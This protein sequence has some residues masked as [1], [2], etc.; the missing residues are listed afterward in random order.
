MCDKPA[1][2]INVYNIL[3]SPLCIEIEDGQKV[4][5]I[6]KRSIEEK[7]KIILSFQNIEVVT[8]AFFNKAIGQLYC[9]YNEEEI[10]TY[11]KVKDMFR[12]DKTLL[13]RTVDTSR[14]RFKTPDEPHEL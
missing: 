9:K 13:R 2:K 4:F 14:L 6:I 11:L 3:N 12:Q 5:E 7:R 1:R 10:K 8:V